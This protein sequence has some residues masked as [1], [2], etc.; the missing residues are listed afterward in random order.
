MVYV[1]MR[2][3]SLDI[4]AHIPNTFPSGIGITVAEFVGYIIFNVICCICI[5]FRPT[6]L[7]PYFH[8]AA[9]V[10]A[11]AL[12]ALLGW[13]VGTSDGFGSV[14]AKSNSSLSGPKLVWQTLSSIMSVIGG[15]AAGILNQ[16][17]FTRFAKRP[18]QVVW[19]QAI[20]F[21]VSASVVS[22]IG[23]F[24]TAATQE[25]ELLCPVKKK[26]KKKKARCYVDTGKYLL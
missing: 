16:N 25:R 4:D 13:A 12:F 21:F 8:G 24:V 10:V 15:I 5:W 14:L 3:I 19:P 6:Q 18:S 1:C 9:V 7:R 20:S 22:I 11:I 17:D 2:S 26:K 23:V